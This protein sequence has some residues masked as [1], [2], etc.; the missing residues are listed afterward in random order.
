MPSSECRQV[1]QRFAERRRDGTAAF[2]GGAMAHRTIFLYIWR[3]DGT[4]AGGNWTF[5][6]FGVNVAVD[7]F[8]WGFPAPATHIIR[9]NRRI[10]VMRV[11]IA[12]SLRTLDWFFCV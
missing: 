11:I 1:R 8:D 9:R 4:Y 10:K 5:W 12:G 6:S 3:P 7:G 2:A